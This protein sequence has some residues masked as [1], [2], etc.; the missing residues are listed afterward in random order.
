[1]AIEQA[2][3]VEVAEQV[4]K[5]IA[6]AQN[7][8]LSIADFQL[9]RN[10]AD[11]DLNLEE[12]NGFALE[13]AEKLFVDVVSHTTEQ[14]YEHS[15]RGKIRYTVPV[16]LAVRKKFGPSEQNLTTDRVKVEKIDELCL[17]TE[18]LHKLFLPIR[19]ANDG[20]PH[21]V[22]DSEKGG[23]RILVNPH[24]EHLRMRQFTA[25]VRMFFKVDRSING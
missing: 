18:T 7:G 8:E 6:E 22:W 1:M 4:K 11:Y 3:I 16:D 9:E 14:E 5:R 10:Y 24:K 20:F 2:T 15:A 12:M 19:L 21:A 23:T 17:F 13:E 25:I